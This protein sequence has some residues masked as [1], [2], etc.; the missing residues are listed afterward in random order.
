MLF[1]G[2]D[3]Y[4]EAFS[5][6]SD[7]DK[8]KDDKKDDK[9]STFGGDKKDEKT[10]PSGAK[11]GDIEDSK[12]WTAFLRQL[13]GSMVQIL[14]FMIIMANVIYLKMLDPAQMEEFFP[15]GGGG[16]QGGG[17]CPEPPGHPPGFDQTIVDSWWNHPKMSTYTA[18][19]DTPDD[20]FG[21]EYWCN[22]TL[23][24]SYDIVRKAMKAYIAF[25]FDAS[26]STILNNMFWQ[27]I[28]LMLGNMFIL[29]VFFIVWI[30]NMFI[31]IKETWYF[32]LT[33]GWL[34]AAFLTCMQFIQFFVSI[35]GV[36][37]ARDFKNNSGKTIKKIIYCNIPTILFLFGFNI[38]MNSSVTFGNVTMFGML[39]WV[40]W[41]TYTS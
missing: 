25:G 18:W 17:G 3:N 6:I 32:G 16:G 15:T 4:Y 8:K 40:I 12:T 24:S 41:A 30:V 9:K 13:A 28:L 21:I 5:L 37:I 33:I 14:V 34:F 19:N 27:G 7:K 22:H 1:G 36:G 2:S 26:T 23:A 35:L 11:I 31:G 10:D 20:G 38:A 29:P 39:I